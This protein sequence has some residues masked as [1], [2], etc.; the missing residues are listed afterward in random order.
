MN[1]S[2]L[3]DEKVKVRFRQIDRRKNTGLR[4]DAIDNYAMETVLELDIVTMLRGVA[5]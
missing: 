2:Q 4:T 1:Q 3:A 5:A